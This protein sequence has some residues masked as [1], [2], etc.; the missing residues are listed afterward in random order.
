MIEFIKTSLRNNANNGIRKLRMFRSNFAP[1]NKNMAVTGVK[2]QGCG[3]NLEMATI[4]TIKIT[5]KYLFC[6]YFISIVLTKVI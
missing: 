4:K 2:F 5:Q 6:V 1:L 3:N